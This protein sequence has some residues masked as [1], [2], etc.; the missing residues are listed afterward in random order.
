M[1]QYKAQVLSYVE[2]RTAAVYHAAD[3]HLKRLDAVQ[4]RFLSEI[5]LSQLQALVDFRLAP[6]SV[7]RDIALLGVIHRAACGGGPLALRKFF[8]KAEERPSLHHLRSDTRRHGRHLAEPGA[9][10]WHERLESFSRSAF[11]L[12]YVYNLL[13][14]ACVESEAVP[15]F[16]GCLQAMVQNAA[17]RG[18]PEWEKLLSPR[19]PRHGHPLKSFR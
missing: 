2:Y 10:H 12:V 16:Q 14:P 4:R 9:E 19:W 7:R 5:G 13:P 8:V 3:V 1:L 18:M 6:L 17:Q 15:Q 11:G